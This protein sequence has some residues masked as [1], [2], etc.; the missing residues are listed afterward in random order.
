MRKNLTIIILMLITA[1]LF[2]TGFSTV[3]DETSFRIR[4]YK[5]NPEADY[6]RIVVTSAIGSYDDI[7]AGDEIKGELDISR[8]LSNYLTGSAQ[9]ENSTTQLIFSVRVV[10]SRQS[11]ET[12]YTLD[13]KCEPFINVSAKGTNAGPTSS[14]D[15]NNIPEDNIIDAFFKVGSTR[16][17]YLDNTKS[18]DKEG[19]NIVNGKGEVSFSNG[20]ANNDT[21]SVT[22]TTEKPATEDP[23]L[24]PAWSAR[25]AVLMAVS[26]IDYD[27]AVNGTYT[28]YITI[29]LTEGS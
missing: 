8:Y 5:I 4:G 29:T 23:N 12:K 28:S 3:G 9:I 10:N 16:F 18:T 13:I 6:G 14:S 25:T 17:L 7:D 2:S 26:S 11:A 22:W 15:I 27:K 24:A 20:V 19:I 21:L 1:S